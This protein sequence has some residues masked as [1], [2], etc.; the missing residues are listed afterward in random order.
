MTGTQEPLTRLAR[1]LSNQV[2]RPVLD[3]T[4][5]K[6]NYDF[7]MTFAPDLA[8]PEGPSVFTALEEQLGLKLDAQKGPVEILV[9][10]GAEH[11][12]AN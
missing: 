7:K 3:R 4:E 9:I 5:L 11:A 8:D 6:G 12:S 2:G 1:M 10:D